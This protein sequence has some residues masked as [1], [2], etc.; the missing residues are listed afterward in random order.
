MLTSFLYLK[1]KQKAKEELQ[2]LV[3]CLYLFLFLFLLCCCFIFLLFS[4]NPWKMMIFPVDVFSPV[5]NLSAVNLS[6][7]SNLSL[8]SSSVSALRP[9]SCSIS[10]LLQ[11]V[12]YHHYR[13]SDWNIDSS[14]DW[15]D[16][17]QLKTAFV[18]NSSSRHSLKVAIHWWQRS[19][20]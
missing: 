20:Q 3:V 11:D 14:I 4:S 5:P 6:S 18:M 2:W 19:W 15:N 17:S 12:D 9:T 8:L 10:T 16:Y 7:P 13:L 1:I